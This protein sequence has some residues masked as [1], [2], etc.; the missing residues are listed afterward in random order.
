MEY[1]RFKCYKILIFGL[2]CKLG[3]FLFKL[4]FIKLSFKKNQTYFFI[5][6]IIFG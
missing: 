4:Y 1:I 2:V 5:F 6:F 3:D